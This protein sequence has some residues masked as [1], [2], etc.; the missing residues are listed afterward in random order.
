MHVPAPQHK[1]ASE[2]YNAYNAR[3]Q[4]DFVHSPIE[5]LSVPSMQQ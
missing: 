1:P 3:E 2:A 4:L 5:D